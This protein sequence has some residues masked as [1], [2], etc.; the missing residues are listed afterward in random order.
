MQEEV[1]RENLSGPWRVSD[2]VILFSSYKN[3]D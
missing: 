2:D 1:T 3:I